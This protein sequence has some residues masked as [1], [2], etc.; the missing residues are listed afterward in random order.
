MAS[1]IEPFSI[2]IEQARLDDLRE[3]LRW[4]RLP[5]PAPVDGWEQ[6]VPIAQIERLRDY[7][8]NQYDWR[9]CEAALNALGS[10]RA[11]IDGLGI[12]FLHVRSPEPS[13]RPLILT[14]G[15][16]GSVIEF[17][18]VAGPL[19]DPAAHGGDPADAFHLVLP[20]LPGYGFSDHPSEPGWTV[21]RVA[22]AWLVLME[23][24]GYRR[25][26]AQGGDWGAGVT[27]AM[28]M[29]APD[30]VAAIHL[31]VSIAQPGPDDVLTPEEQA[32]AAAFRRHNQ[33][34]RGY[35]EQQSTRPQT[36]G[37]GLA[38]SP[39]GQ[40]AW[41]Y[42]KYREWSDC[43]DD[44][45]NVYSMDEMLDNITV[46]WLTNSG[47]SSGRMYWENRARDRMVTV[48]VPVGISIFPRELFR[49]SRRIAQRLFPTLS[50]WNEVSKGGHFAAF[51][52]PDLFVEE[53][54]ACFRLAE[55]RN[56]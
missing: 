31:N 3:R 6:G 48:K 12:H 29:Q 28:A 21:D 19:T 26:L 1:W 18:K 5:D 34:G 49:S 13:A 44:P 55:A 51:E 22:A 10:F 50:Y 16:P 37:Y 54:R 45:T 33:M 9:R 25:F 36:L 41:I 17:L 8:L 40:A 42:E 53:V 24:L 47:T 38:D 15:W 39:I 20:S 52:V 32:I 11:G 7:W 35:A 56:V 30:R 4:T 27:P 43:G 46:Y 23:R 2:A 14:H